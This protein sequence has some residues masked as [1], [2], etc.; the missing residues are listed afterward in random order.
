[1]RFVWRQTPSGLVRLELM[2][3]NERTQGALVLECF[4]DSSREFLAEFL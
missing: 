2:R 3:L 4:R 1:V